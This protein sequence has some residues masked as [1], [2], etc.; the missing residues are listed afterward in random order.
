[1]HVAMPC[2]R[3]IT[4]LR[5]WVLAWFMVSL[6]LAVA[7]PL[8][9]P[10]SMELVCSSA[11]AVKVI[12]HDDDG[13]QELGS[14]AVACVLCSVTAPPPS[15]IRV[16]LPRPLPLAH[17]VQSIPSARLAAVTRSP[18]PARGPPHLS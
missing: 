15:T 18:L 17:A 13:A 12:V 1:M 2:P 6:G 5:R 7:A 8:I 16:Q 14:T 10:Q 3:H 4:F 11:G 9:H